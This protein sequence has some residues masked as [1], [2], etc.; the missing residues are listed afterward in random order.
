[1][2]LN[3]IEALVEKYI[4]GETSISEEKELKN[5]FTSTE[6]APLLEHY[7]PM[8]GYFAKAKNETS[9][10]EIILKQKKKNKLAWLSVAAAIVV[11]FGAGFY[12]YNNSMVPSKEDLGTSD[13]PEMAF[14]ETQKAL[15]LISTH[16]NTS[17]E[18]MSYINEFELSKNKIFKK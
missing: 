6:V 10:R 9:S 5:Y 18:G 16:L 12:V 15:D 2:E 1:M 4:Q 8:F 11:L 13:N 3:K 17:Y 14:K 7:K